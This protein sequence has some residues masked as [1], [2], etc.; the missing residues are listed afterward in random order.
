MARDINEKKWQRESV[1][2]FYKSVAEVGKS[3]IYKPFVSRLKTN[4]ASEIV[5][6]LG[7]FPGFVEHK[8]DLKVK[9]MIDHN[10]TLTVR[11]WEST[12]GFTEYEFND[13][14]DFYK[15]RVTG[16]AGSLINHPTSL[17]FTNLVDN[18]VCYDGQ[19]FFATDHIYINSEDREATYSNLVTGTGITAALI[20]ANFDTGKKN[21]RDLKQRNGESLFADLGE[22]TVVCSSDLESVMDNVFNF[23]NDGD[24]LHYKKAKVM[25][26]GNLSGSDWYMFLLDKPMKPFIFLDREN[27]RAEW[28]MELF[29]T[30]SKF[31]FQAK[32]RYS[33][34][35]G[36]PQLAQ[37]I[38]N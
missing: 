11:N 18:N 23:P 15:S 25:V 3:A 9:A 22:I 19:E 1:N 2:N 36:F 24:N 10:F 35:N 8:D 28:N 21:L 31:N 26:S 38:D 32:A 6:W 12:L 20:K 29:K 33:I 34:G 27:L 37:K 13:S 14:P 17:M 16:L 4:S 5:A 7:D 30:N